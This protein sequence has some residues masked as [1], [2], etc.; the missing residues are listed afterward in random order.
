MLFLTT[1]S[2]SFSHPFT[3]R[4]PVVVVGWAAGDSTLS[5]S[6]PVHVLYFLW[7]PS[8]KQAIDLMGWRMLRGLTRRSGAAL[9]AAAEEH[10]GRLRK[11]RKGNSLDCDSSCIMLAAA[12]KEFQWDHFFCEMKCG[13]LL[14]HVSYHRRRTSSTLRD[15][16]LCWTDL[17]SDTVVDREK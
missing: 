14:Q 11:Y 5:L 2:S 9:S 8:P 6:F 13:I 17:T 15:I 12:F 1:I 4:F 10:P 16:V 7:L 3:L